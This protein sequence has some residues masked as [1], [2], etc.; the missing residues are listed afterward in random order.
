MTDK[1]CIAASY[2]LL[3]LLLAFVGGFVVGLCL[4]INLHEVLAP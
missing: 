4:G 1:Q 3:G 2:V